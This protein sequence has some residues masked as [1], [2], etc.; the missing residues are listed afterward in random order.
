[1]NNKLIMSILGLVIGVI[2]LSAVLVPVLDEAQKSAGDTVEYVNTGAV[3]KI[4]ESTEEYTLV[5][6]Y[7]SH[8]MELN[9]VTVSTASPRIN[10]ISTDSI[11]VGQN[12]G[13]T[14]VFIATSDGEYSGSNLYHDFTV[15]LLNGEYTIIDQNKTTSGDYNWA[16]VY[17]PDG[18]RVDLSTSAYFNNPNELVSSGIYTTGEL[19]CY[20]SLENGIVTVS[21][22][23]TGSVEYIMDLVSGTTDIYCGTA[24]ITVTDGAITETFAPYILGY[25]E[26][27]SG[28]EN[29]GGAYSLYGAIPVLVIVGLIVAS[30]ATLRPRD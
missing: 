17:S 21:N 15:H 1:M 30:V 4:V 9:G 16:Y 19:D 5:F 6:H 8:T 7:A 23:Y 27:V 2:V 22:G 14:G 13:G 25:Y 24:T 12:Y 26:K 18:N 28:H 3:H 11:T 10:W 20:F 29:K